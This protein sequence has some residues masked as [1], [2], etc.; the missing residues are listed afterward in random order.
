[1]F[2]YYQYRS[3]DQD[4][5]RLRNLEA[6]GVEAVLPSDKTCSGS[7]REQW[8]LVSGTLTATI[9]HASQGTKDPGLPS[10]RLFLGD[11]TQD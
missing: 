8:M 6:L 9:I 7:L 2:H 3:E 1:M 4:P 10:I 11:L 5:Q